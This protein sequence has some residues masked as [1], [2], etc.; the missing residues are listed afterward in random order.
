MLLTK[1]ELADR[2]LSQERLA[3]ALRVFR[4]TGLIVLENLLNVDWIAE[5]RQAYDNALNAHMAATG[6]LAA[7]QQTPTEKNHL[8]FYP[9]LI[10]PFSDPRIIA[11]PLAVQI[12]EALLGKDLQCTY[13]HSN[14]SYPGSGTQ[15]V[16]RDAGHLFGAAFPCALPVTHLALNVP[17]CDFT[18]ANGSTEVWPGTHLIVDADGADSNRLN[19]RVAGLPSIRTNLPAGSLVL[20]DLRTWHRGMPNTTEAPRTMLALIYRRG[21]LASN[22]TL[23]ISQTVWDEWPERAC[24]IFRGNRVHS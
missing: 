24:Q 3:E 17:L 8:S 15:N 1:E 22:S 6:G 7:V 18:E 2:A 14:T 23:A 11:N 20:R 5:V 19:E 13:Y 4:D 12:M 21:W 10:A 9:P 16:H